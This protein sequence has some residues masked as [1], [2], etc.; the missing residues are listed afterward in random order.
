MGANTVVLRVPAQS[1]IMELRKIS[2]LT[3]KAIDAFEG[4]REGWSNTLVAT[5]L[6]VA[7]VP[8]PKIRDRTIDEWTRVV[9]ATREDDQQMGALAAAALKVCGYAATVTLLPTGDDDEV[10]D[11]IAEVDEA[12]GDLPT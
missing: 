4:G 8:A 5:C 10:I 11:R 1:E 7:V 6:K 2:D 12:A 9:L 3:S